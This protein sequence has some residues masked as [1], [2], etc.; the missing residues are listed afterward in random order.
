MA[1]YV[2]PPVSLAPSPAPPVAVFVPPPATPVPPLAPSVAVQVPPP[3][4]LVAAPIAGTSS[5]QFVPVTGNINFF[6]SVCLIL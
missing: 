4:V 5:V 1:V 3:A 2:S 6:Y